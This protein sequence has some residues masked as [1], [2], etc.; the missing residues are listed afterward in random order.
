[1]SI[2]LICAFDEVRSGVLGSSFVERRLYAFLV[3]SAAA[4]CPAACA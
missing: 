4:A 3:T 1:V 2:L